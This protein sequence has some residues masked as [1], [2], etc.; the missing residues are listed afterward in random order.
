MTTATLSRYGFTLRPDYTRISSA[1][2]VK[3]VSAN[4]IVWALGKEAV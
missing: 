3:Y 1:P 2:S 4:I